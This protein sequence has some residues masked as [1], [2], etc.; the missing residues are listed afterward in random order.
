M[1]GRLVSPWGHTRKAS[2]AAGR[3]GEISTMNGDN[4]M[5]WFTAETKRRREPS[6]EDVHEQRQ[7]AE[8][9]LESTSTPLFA[10]DTDH[11]V[12]TWNRAMVALTG[13]PAEEMV[14]TDHQWQPFYP[15]PRPTYYV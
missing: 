13:I 7:F 15:Q 9:L 6:G 11:R 1:Q 10:I 3:S 2:S 4:N 14:G 8:I 5:A 12:V